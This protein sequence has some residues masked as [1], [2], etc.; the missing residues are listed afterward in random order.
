M[1]PAGIMLNVLHVFF[2]YISC[3]NPKLSGHY[4]CLHLQRRKLTHRNVTRLP[5]H[6]VV[7]LGSQ[8]DSGCTLDCAVLPRCAGGRGGIKY[9]WS[10][11]SNIHI[12]RLNQDTGSPQSPTTY[13]GTLVST[14]DFSTFSQL[15]PDDHSDN[16]LFSQY[17][18]QKQGEWLSPDSHGEWSLQC[19]QS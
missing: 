14:Q 10:Q 17:L 1:F 16:Q 5:G 2:S 19:T 3:N 12:L 11:V 18:S 7:R 6:S 15:F 9:L 8:S 4:H 13:S